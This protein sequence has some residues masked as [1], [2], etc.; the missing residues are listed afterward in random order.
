MA[1]IPKSFKIFT[2]HCAHS[3]T[4]IDATLV[5]SEAQLIEFKSG[6]ATLQFTLQNNEGLTVKH[7]VVRTSD[8]KV[9]FYYRRIDGNDTNWHAQ[10]N[11][12]TYVT[13]AAELAEHFHWFKELSEN[14]FVSLA[15]W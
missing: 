15:N 14:V 13:N 5:I 8:L 9:E 4:F 2:M 3:Y 7:T 11:R 1:T 6:D 10:E 12:N